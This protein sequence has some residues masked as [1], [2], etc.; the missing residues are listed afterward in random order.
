MN[1]RILIVDDDPE[2]RRLIGMILQRS[3]FEPIPVPGGAEALEYLAHDVPDLIILDVMM[4]HMDGNEVCQRIREDS[5]TARVPVVMLTARSETANQVEGLLAGADDY[6][7]K[8]STR[9]ELIA[10]IQAALARAASAPQKRT[11][12]VISVL[13]ARGGVG[14]TT[15]AVNLA[16]LFAAQSRTLLIDFESGGTAALYLGLSPTHGLDDLLAYPT[17]SLDLASLQAALT[18]HASGL[19]VL[20]AA[21]APVGVVRAG[22]ILNHLRAAYDVCVCDLGAGLT[23]LIQSLAPRSNTVI[24]ALDSDRVTLAQ[25]EKVI[26]ESSEA[27]S[28]WPKVR[29]VRVNRLG[30][31]DDTAQ[32]AIHSA[33]GQEAAVIGPASEA[34]YQ[35]LECGQPLV[36]N[37]P[38]HP[39]AAQMRALANSLMSAA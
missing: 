17:D 36:M 35:S 10:S 5:R 6:L 11:A 15:L 28:L 38:D 1:P 21:L 20:A 16:V 13:G 7:V 31:P 32:A 19:S 39:V 8:P 23:P 26:G 29:L 18:P 24:L 2:A 30:A 33:L 9:E 34:M 22:V 12:H 25:A 37:Q 14:A 3:G 4:P 27:E